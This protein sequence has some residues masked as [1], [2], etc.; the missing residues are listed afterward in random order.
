MAAPDD[1]D[2]RDNDVL[3]MVRYALRARDPIMLRAVAKLFNSR[4]DHEEAVAAVLKGFPEAASTDKPT[5]AAKPTAGDAK[6]AE[7]APEAP[8]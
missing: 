4:A 5:Q 3:R 6:P 1:F 2:V 7:P 8:E